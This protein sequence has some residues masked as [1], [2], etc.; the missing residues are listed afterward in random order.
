MKTFSFIRS[1]GAFHGLGVFLLFA[2]GAFQKGDAS[3]WGAYHIVSAST[4]EFVLEAVDGVKEGATISI[5]KPNGG[6]NQKWIVIEEEGVAKISP[7]EGP[8]LV[9]SAAEGGANRGTAIVLEKD[10]GEPWQRWSLVK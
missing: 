7:V 8:S 6:A 2:M 1:I 3:D 4:S 5:Q 10:R 9:M